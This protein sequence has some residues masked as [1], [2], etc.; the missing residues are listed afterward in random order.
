M[1]LVLTSILP[2]LHLSGQC[3]ADD[4]NTIKYLTGLNHAP[5]KV[6]V[7]CERA[8]LA[9]LDGNCRTPIAGQAYLEG[10]VLKFSGIISKV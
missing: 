10:N 5:T 2:S 1:A 6:C 9:T 7:D 3:R 4:E 8:F